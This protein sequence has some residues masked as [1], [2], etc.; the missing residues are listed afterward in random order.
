MIVCI[1][2]LAR[3]YRQTPSFSRIHQGDFP[4]LA[5][6]RY[7]KERIGTDS[8]NYVSMKYATL[9]NSKHNHVELA[10]LQHQTYPAQGTVA[11]SRQSSSAACRCFNGPAAYSSLSTNFRNAAKFVYHT[12]PTRSQ[13]SFPSKG[14]ASIL[15]WNFPSHSGFMAAPE[16]SPH[17]A[18]I[19]RML[20]T[21]RVR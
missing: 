18:V 21:Y 10:S 14:P 1:E 8:A 19:F 7:S 6:A 12:M 20:A 16:S 3:P 2:A 15:A 13:A 11:K 4:E 9:C 17:A 5:F